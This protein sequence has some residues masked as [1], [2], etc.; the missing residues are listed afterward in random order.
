MRV[1]ALIDSGADASMLPIQVLQAV[2]AQYI[3]TRYIRGVTGTRQAAETFLAIIQVGP[4]L[5]VTSDAIAV[6]Q[7]EDT[8]LGRDV[9]N[10]L[11]VTLDGPSHMT[12]IA[13]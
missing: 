8:I 13:E 1:N 11:V 12:E 7:G 2:G 6:V 5:V 10:S 4:Q 9:L 3:E